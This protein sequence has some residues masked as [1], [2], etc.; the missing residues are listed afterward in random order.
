M[1][2]IGRYC[3]FRFD[4]NFIFFFLFLN[5][6]YGT[7]EQFQYKKKMENQEWNDDV[8][9]F[10]SSLLFSPYCCV[11]ILM[12]CMDSL[13][14]LVCLLT[15][16]RYFKRQIFFL[17]ILFV[18]QKKK[19]WAKFIIIIYCSKWNDMWLVFVFVCIGRHRSQ[20]LC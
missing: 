12:G 2:M 4:F 14:L 10:F 9:Y 5:A 6:Q 15:N 1:P 11:F 7:F 13:A 3:K 8:M 18:F 16:T 17:K 19:K 20:I